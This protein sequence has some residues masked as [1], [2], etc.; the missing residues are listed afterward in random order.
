MSFYL[1][2]VQEECFIK[3]RTLE[4]S[5]PGSLSTSGVIIVVSCLLGSIVVGSYFKYALYRYMYDNRKEIQNK[6]IDLLLLIKA[7]IDHCICILLVLTYTIGLTLDIT[8]SDY[9]GEAW[10]NVLWY[11]ATFGLAYRTY[12]RLGIAV[13]RLFYIKFPYQVRNNTFRRKMMITVLLSS[14]AISTIIAIGFGMGNGEASRKQV[15]WNFCTGRSAGFREL[16]HSYS[17]LQ[18]KVVP[19]SEMIPKLVVGISIAAVIT[20]FL[21]YILFFKHLYSHDEELLKKRV[22]KMNEVRKRHRKN[23]ITFLGQFYTFVVGCARGSLLAYTM[24]SDT[25]VNSRL[26][27]VL[28]IWV[29][30]GILSAVEVMT[31]KGL[32]KY[33]PHNRKFF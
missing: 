17:L 20:E 8:F 12:G 1:N 32:K 24:K 28:S 25:D 18:G 2:G 31:S 23:A 21:C 33:L 27:I 15:N 14:L 16:M 7:L 4:Q 9:L 11:A 29:E 10:C 30:F 3:D 19:D 6:P 22:L 26:L 13:L 5:A